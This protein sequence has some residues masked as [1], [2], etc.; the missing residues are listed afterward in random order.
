VVKGS[1]EPLFD[2][3]IED[4]LNELRSLQTT[5]PEPPPEVAQQYL[6]K[7]F[8]LRFRDTAQ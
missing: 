7:P 1:G 2:Q 6:G 4:R 8:T 5:V 3:S